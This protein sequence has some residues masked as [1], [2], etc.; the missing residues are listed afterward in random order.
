MDLT[1][2]CEN[3]PIY[4]NE[5]SLTDNLHNDYV[6]CNIPGP[7]INPDD[8]VKNATGCGCE[9]DC[10]NFEGR[11]CPCVKYGLLYAAD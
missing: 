6:P 4:M 5:E 7:G 3:F 10:D 1:Q 11:T 2:G 8:F 9:I